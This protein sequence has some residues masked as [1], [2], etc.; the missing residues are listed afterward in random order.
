MRRKLL[1]RGSGVAPWWGVRTT[2]ADPLGRWH[3]IEHPTGERE[4]Y[5]LA[6]DPW[7]ME[8][9]DGRWRYAATEAALASRL[10]RLRA[11]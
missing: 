1:E 7:E 4:L 9:V 8:S 10:D 5:D 6:V 11:E 3:Y 2:R